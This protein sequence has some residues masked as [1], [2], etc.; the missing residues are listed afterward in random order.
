M[1][2]VF[3]FDIETIPDVAGLRIL[4]ALPARLSDAEVAD[5]AFQHCRAKNGSDF[6]PHYLQRVV[7]ISCA[8]RDEKNFQIFSLS[9]PEL[10]EITIIQ[11]FFDGIE[12][13]TPQVVSWNGS[14]FDMPVLHYRSLMHGVVASRYWDV[15]QGG[16][17]DS[18][19]F[20]T[21]N[22]INRYHARHLDLMGMLALHQSR[23]NAP[24]DDLAKLAGFPG[25]LDMDGSQ[26]WQAYQDGRIGDIRRYCEIDVINTY[27]VFLRFQLMR[28]V[29]SKETYAQE[30]A[31]VRDTLN[32]NEASH[33]QVFLQA[34]PMDSSA[35]GAV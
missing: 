21:N 17:S 5:Y 13:W 6:L 16:Y 29:L 4:H 25:K 34:W 10:N 12:K 30:T 14:G 20:K 18:C 32:R 8:M 24:L 28:G 27:L 19:D 22:Y 31:V 9:E 11:R 1:S 33:W 23:A 7:T 15:G 3:V 35:A 26:V 2:P